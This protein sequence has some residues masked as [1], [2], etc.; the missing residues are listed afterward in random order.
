[1][2]DHYH[3]KTPQY[4]FHC[5]KELERDWIDKGKPY[6]HC[7]TCDLYWTQKDLRLEKKQRKTIEDFNT[8]GKVKQQEPEEHDYTGTLFDVTAQNKGGA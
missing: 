8:T 3:Y 6:Y 5:G 4:C 2:S 1:M 7:P